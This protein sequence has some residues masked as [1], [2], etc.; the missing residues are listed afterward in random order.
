MRQFISTAALCFSFL[1]MLL[2]QSTEAT[3]QIPDKFTNL[4]VLS[5]ETPKAELV[6]IMRTYAGD[7]GVRCG[8]CHT[9][10]DPN[11][12]QGVNFASD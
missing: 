8:F 2:A 3:A 5:K 7:L 11:T 12:L 1:V 4:Q 6:S 9:G 10:G